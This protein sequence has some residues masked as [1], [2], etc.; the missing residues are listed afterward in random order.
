ME[1]PMQAFLKPCTPWYWHGWDDN[2]VSNVAPSHIS[3]WWPTVYGSALITSTC[4]AGLILYCWNY[5][6][7]SY[8]LTLVCTC[9]HVCTYVNICTYNIYIWPEWLM[10]CFP[11]I[12]TQSR[13]TASIRSQSVSASIL[14]FNIY[15][16]TQAKF[17]RPRCSCVACWIVDM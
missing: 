17:T 10:G 9:I 14:F 3:P 12:I 6:I 15:G 13:S 16:L 1:K 2:V 4:I 5:L 11:L 7:V 8:G